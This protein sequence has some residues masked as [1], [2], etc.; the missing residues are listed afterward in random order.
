MLSTARMTSERGPSGDPTPFQ[1][2]PPSSPMKVG[3]SDAPVLEV[4]LGEGDGDR[5]KAAT[6]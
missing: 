5:W 4:I 3:A 2:T 6:R 1:N